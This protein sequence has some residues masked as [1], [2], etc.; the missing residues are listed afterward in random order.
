MSE[1]RTRTAEEVAD[2]AASLLDDVQHVHRAGAQLAGST[3]DRDLLSQ[4]QLTLAL[5]ERLAAQVEDLA[6]VVAWPQDYEP[7][8]P[9]QTVEI[10]E[11]GDLDWHGHL[12]AALQH[13]DAVLNDSPD[14]IQASVKR[15]WT[16]L[17]RL[18]QAISDGEV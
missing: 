2:H 4:S 3:V 5:V 9:E 16:N 13:L 10:V 18:L 12:L 8:H 11:P 1:P 6:A 15:P 17:S 7:E 14:D